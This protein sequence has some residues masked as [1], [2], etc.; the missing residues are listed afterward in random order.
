MLCHCEMCLHIRGHH[1]QQL[2]QS[3]RNLSDFCKTIFQTWMDPPLACVMVVFS[4]C[5]ISWQPT[6]HSAHKTSQHTAQNWTHFSV[7][8]LL[9]IING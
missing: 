1:L 4:F 9:I 8:P 5:M 3:H 7:Y 6:V 2:L